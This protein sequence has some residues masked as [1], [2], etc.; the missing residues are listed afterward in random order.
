MKNLP[1]PKF[2]G[3]TRII[4]PNGTE[5]VIVST[6]YEIDGTIHHLCF[7]P[8]KNMKKQVFMQPI[9]FAETDLKLAN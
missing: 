6:R 7:V 9:S 8:L 1:N 3:G 2:A 4:T 5:S